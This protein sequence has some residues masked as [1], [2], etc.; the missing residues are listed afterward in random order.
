MKNRILV[1]FSVAVWFSLNLTHSIYSQSLYV[2]EDGLISYV[3]PE[4]FVLTDV[5]YEFHDVI[6]ENY[7]M[8]YK[9]SISD[10]NPSI[11][12]NTTIMDNN[13]VIDESIAHYQRE[14][15]S[16]I[17]TKV[18]IDGIRQFN[19][20]NVNNVLEVFFL[21][22]GLNDEKVINLIYYFQENLNL[23]SNRLWTMTFT[24]SY[25]E[26]STY[27]PIAEKAARSFKIKRISN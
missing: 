16:K 12:I 23:S 9:E 15:L 13:I 1:W 17:H 19:T 20:K 25:S 27:S 5:P 22:E 7:K 18:L 6:N 8:A 21:I 26:K 2:S 24:F 4:G 11:L 14:L 3:V 10:I